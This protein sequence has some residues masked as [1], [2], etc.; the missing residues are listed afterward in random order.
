[1]AE[2]LDDATKQRE[3]RTVRELIGQLPDEAINRDD[4]ARWERFI[5]DLTDAQRT[6]LEQLGLERM[7]EE[8]IAGEKGGDE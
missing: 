3:L 4:P 2:P 6:A 5:E 8:A 1:M 7:A